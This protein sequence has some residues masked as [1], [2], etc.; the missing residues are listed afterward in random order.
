MQTRWGLW[1]LLVV[2]AACSV[3]TGWPP[4]E[5][6]RVLQD[7]LARLD[8]QEYCECSTEAIT[9]TFDYVEFSSQDISDR[10]VLEVVSEECG[11]LLED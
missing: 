2:L 9:S 8:S 1:V 4:E 10:D 6:E 3:N 5:E 11:D 7:C